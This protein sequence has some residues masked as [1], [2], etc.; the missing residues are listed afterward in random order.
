[1]AAAPGAK[2]ETLERFRKGRKAEF[3]P[4]ETVADPRTQEAYARIS[5]GEA[6]LAKG[7]IEMAL[8]NLRAAS[9]LL[10]NDAD[11]KALLALATWRN[12]SLATAI[13]ASKARALLSEAVAVKP[14]CARAY[15][16]FGLL[17]AEQGQLEHAIRCYTK[18]RELVPGDVEAAREVS[19]LEKKRSRSLRGLFRRV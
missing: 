19:R 15:R 18:V 13:R 9:T 2:L 10:P 7:E 12:R 5:R 17:Y 16:V 11:V 4:Q 14:T 1:V 8:A 3:P 6:Y